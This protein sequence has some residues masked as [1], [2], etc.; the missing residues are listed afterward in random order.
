LSGSAP[1][2]IGTHPHMSLSSSP[3][4]A[5][6]GV[7]GAVGQEFLRLIEERGLPHRELRMLASARSAGT[8]VECGGRRYEVQELNEGSFEGVDL[9]LFSA[10]R[11]VSRLMAPV[12]VRSGAVVVDNSSCFRMDPAIPLVTPEVNGEVLDDL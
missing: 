3:T 11:T 6:V 7:T 1:P 8:E 5:I 4:V 9:A 12:A 2:S 10:G